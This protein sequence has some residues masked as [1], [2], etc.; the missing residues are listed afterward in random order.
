MSLADGLRAL[1]CVVLTTL[2]PAQSPRPQTCRGCAPATTHVAYRGGGGALWW[3][4]WSWR[5]GTNA[6]NK[7]E[8]LLQLSHTITRVGTNL[9]VIPVTVQYVESSV[10]V[11]HSRPGPL[12]RVAWIILHS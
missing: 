7:F 1:R 6:H 5:V 4:Q 9:V 12:V 11:V 2:E 10:R 3:Y 8:L